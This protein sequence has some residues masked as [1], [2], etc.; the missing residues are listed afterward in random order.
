MYFRNRDANCEIIKKNKDENAH[1]YAVSGG[2][3]LIWCREFDKYIFKGC[4]INIPPTPHKFDYDP[5]PA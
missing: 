4:N 5:A 2:D 3:L 1:R